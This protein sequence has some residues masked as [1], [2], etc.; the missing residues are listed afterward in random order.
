MPRGRI[1]TPTSHRKKSLC[2]MLNGKQILS[3]MQETLS[4]FLEGK[5]HQ[6]TQ[7]C[8]LCVLGH[9]SH[10][11]EMKVSMSGRLSAG[12]LLKY[13]FWRSEYFSLAPPTMTSR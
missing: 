3:K 13:S 11:W 6:T 2:K 7:R 12:S 4:Y 1:E 8:I 10:C 5:G 9:L